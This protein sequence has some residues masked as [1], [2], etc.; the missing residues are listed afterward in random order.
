[1]T[2]I[3]ALMKKNLTNEMAS[4][5]MK[6]FE[7]K[8]TP[9][10][11]FWAISLLLSIS[12]SS[13]LIVE[14]F[15]SYFNYEVSTTSRTLFE[16]PTLFPKVTICNYNPFT[17]AYAL[18]FLKQVNR[19]IAP[20]FD[21]FA[22]E[23]ESNKSTSIA[24]LKEVAYQ[25]YGLAASK[26]LNKNFS[27]AERKKLGHSLE[28]IMYNCYFNNEPCSGSDFIWK[29]DRF[30]GNCYIFNSG[31]DDH[32]NRI[33]LKKSLIAGS[34]FGLK[35]EMYANFNQN[36]N[37]INSPFGPAI[38]V[39]IENSSAPNGGDTFNGIQLATGFI[40][41]VSVDREFKFNLAKPYSNCDISPD[42]TLSSNSFRSDLFRLIV[43]SPYEY[44]QEMCLYQCLQAKIIE[45]C[46]CT[47]PLF[48]SL[49]TGA[50][51]C[52]TEYENNC[53][54]GLFRAK[55]LTDYIREKCLPVCPLE[56]NT[57]EYKASLS[58]ARLVGDTYAYFI[59]ENAN[60]ISDFDNKTVSGEQASK[61]F[62]HMRMSYDSLSYTLTT[63][64]PKVDLVSLLSSIGG[65][66]GLFLGVSALSL[67][68]IIEVFMEFIILKD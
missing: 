52:E 21:F 6:I 46:N 34:Q 47:N 4:G 39:R 59:N 58:L 48:T 23:T 66:L 62:V 15:I 29:F 9:I 22:T 68:E 17:T 31:F 42:D 65:T 3:K 28:D 19:E 49:F 26:M 36:L 10:K 25:I 67:C 30:Y 37:K 32:G 54:N 64:S 43:D 61:S 5:F 57:T 35:L 38:Y 44:K 8:Q 27:N 60:L 1:M 40:T 16:T 56:C 20:D 7:T 53:M 11:L 2:G 33:E 14:S 63:E 24:F 41:Y 50:R 51:E 12:L 13:Y 45:N 18:D 55:I